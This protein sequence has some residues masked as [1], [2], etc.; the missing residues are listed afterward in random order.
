MK[1]TDRPNITIKHLLESRTF[2]L[3]LITYLFLSI[4][5]GNTDLETQVNPSVN[6][7]FDFGP[8]I[9]AFALLSPFVFLISYL[10]ILLLKRRT[11]FIYSALH[12]A[13]IILTSVVSFYFYGAD[14]II[15]MLFLVQLLIFLL[16]LLVVFGFLTKK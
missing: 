7:S 1:K 3:I 16:N 15:F 2:F 14:R 6:N 5:T 9:A 11:S 12:L 10:I 13:V 8:W 4:A